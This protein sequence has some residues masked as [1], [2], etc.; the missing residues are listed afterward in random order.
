[1]MS[2]K[3]V[4]VCLLVVFLFGIC[5]YQ[6]LS[7][8]QLLSPSGRSE[9]N[10]R[11]PLSQNAANALSNS[12]IQVYTKGWSYSLGWF[13]PFG[14][15]E[16]EERYL[17]V[18]RAT[19]SGTFKASLWQSGDVLFNESVLNIGFQH[20]I[21]RFYLSVQP[22]LKQIKVQGYSSFIDWNTQAF[23][24]LRLNNNWLY[25]ALIEWD[26]PSNGLND[27]SFPVKTLKTT[28]GTHFTVSS[29]YAIGIELSQSYLGQLDLRIAQK[30]SL[31]KNT[32]QLSSGYDM[33]RSMPTVG[34][35]M[36][37]N[38]LHVQFHYSYHPTLTQS[39]G[40]AIHF[41]SQSL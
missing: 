30:L 7:A 28:A 5:S 3:T 4:F 19:K 18:Y 37:L 40:G 24:G 26:P 17:A 35:I 2:K 34:L 1:M 23:F 20:S 12:F 10:L 32:L 27:V 25:Y 33:L 22:Q 16:L 15:K 9:G 8:Q 31:V 13:R 21:D 11:N 41:E 38:R 39:S 6:K 29:S 14:F 36:Q